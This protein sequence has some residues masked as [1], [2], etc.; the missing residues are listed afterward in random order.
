MSRAANVMVGALAVAKDAWGDE[1]PEW[2]VDLARECEAT[3]QNKVAARMEYSAAL[4][5]Q[6]L[7][8]KYP[9]DL[10]AVREVFDGVFRNATVACPALGD[11]PG[12]DCRSYR[13]QAKVFAPSSNFRARMYRACRGCP[14]NQKEASQ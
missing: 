8:N 2:V 10:T 6:L 7:R 4:I 13:A 12:Q 9:G 1:L 14:R 3:S 11:I 5:S